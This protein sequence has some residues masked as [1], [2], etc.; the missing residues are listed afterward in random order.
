MVH[1]LSQIEM[2]GSHRGGS[3]DAGGEGDLVVHILLP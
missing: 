2:E 3:N 1:N